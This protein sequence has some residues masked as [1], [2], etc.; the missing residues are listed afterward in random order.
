[1]NNNF[2]D[3][4]IFGFLVLKLLQHKKFPRILFLFG[5]FGGFFLWHRNERNESISQSVYSGVKDENGL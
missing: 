5:F 2:C 1:M 4:L 3:S